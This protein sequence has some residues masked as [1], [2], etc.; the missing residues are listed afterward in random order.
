M[1]VNGTRFH[2]IKGNADWRA[3]FEERADG[4]RVLKWE[5][6]FLDT[7]KSVVTLN[8]LLL[9][10]L[11][12]RGRMPL[13]LAARRGAAADMYGNWYWIS[14][15]RKQIFWRPA[16]TNKTSVYWEQ[17]GK[18][19]PECDPG[20]FTP[21]VPPQP[22]IVE[23]SGLVVT[24]HHYLVVGNL[25]ARGL[26]IFDLHAGGDPTLLLFPPNVPFVPFD[27]APAPGGGLWIL[28]RA[29]RAYW[30]LDR[31][32]RVVSEQ[33]FL[34]EIA[35]EERFT[36]HEVGRGATVRP[37][38]RFPEGFP[39]NETV[40]PVAIEPL[41][42]GGVLILDSPA[43]SLPESSPPTPSVVHRYELSEH[44]EAV[45]LVGDVNSISAGSPSER[46]SLSVVGYDFAY[47]P[48]EHLLYVVEREGNQAIAFTLDFDASP[49][50]FEIRRDFVPMHFFGSRA[51]V[52][53]EGQVFYDVVGGDPT[54][55]TAV[56]FV[57]LQEIEQEHYT[58]DAVLYAP[59]FD[60][61][62]RDCVWHRLFL[63]ACIPPEAH[64]EVWTR[65]HNDRELLEAVPFALEPT[66]YLRGA[67]AELPYFNPFPQFETLPEGTGTW[68]LLFQRAKGRYLE[69]KLVL[70]GNGRVSPHLHALRA[71]YPRFSYPQKY[72]PNVY[73]E[74]EESRSFLDRFLANH[75][76]FYSDI[77]GK[78]A[79]VSVLFDA[80]SAPPETLDW[81]AS[82]VGLVLDPLWAGL[83]QKRAASTTF[84]GAR[85]PDRRRL[86]IRF[87]RKLYDTRGTHPGIL[88]ALNLLLDPCLEVILRR[89]K[90][91][92]LR[93]DLFAVFLEEL[94]LWDLPRPRP[95]MS[96][97]EFEDLLYD[98][99]L[100]PKRPTKVRIV[101]RYRTRG[102]L[103]AVAG[104]PN[105]Q[106]PDEAAHKFSVLVPEA[107][108]AEEALMVERVAG[109]EKPAH[110]LF[111]V[112]RYWDAFRVGE[113]RLGIDTLLGESS[114]FELIVLGGNYLAEGYL[115]PP[116]PLDVEDRL[117]S[118]RDHVGELPPL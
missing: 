25:D 56:R 57:K 14:N 6:L 92:A 102:G 29:N 118:D 95:W 114:R 101:E 78:I 46:T 8:P 11:N 1:D 50:A 4:T 93:P 113:A 13:D 68:E 32:F 5:N 40:D 75:E 96:E 15:D 90:S 111:D 19:E 64:V 110:T 55:D 30:G 24:A 16:G 117:V 67:G 104:D 100:S 53:H 116:H 63:D 33:A 47:L 69:I 51:L 49:N 34:H 72:L 106:S 99:V 61:K 88:F 3:C 109:L 70:S 85:P 65:A 12:A 84:A 39:L 76:G 82:W 58:R 97:Q 41:P 22:T 44:L 37:A 21:R 80:R 23:L 86:F 42:D 45:A 52:A 59:V 27:M 91:A 108:T 31:Q 112:R 103:S 62:E 74:D 17:T 60:G 10:F 81:L 87:A 28:D 115:H 107:L 36:F 2:L 43:V 9:L 73:L 38:R 66:L 89:L 105:Q 54:R 79:D 18:G 35:P 83:Q 7:R 48:A 26:F 94:D 77:E 71:Y 20:D 98:Y